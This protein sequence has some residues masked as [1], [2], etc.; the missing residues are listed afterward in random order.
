MRAIVFD[1][2]LRF[3]ANRPDPRPGDGECLIRI[4]QAG[5]CATDLHIIKGYMGFR[6]VPGHEF[7]GTVFNS[8]PAWQG[9]RVVAEINCV[10]R[11]CDMC[12][13]GLANHCRSRRVIGIADHDGAFADYVCVPERNLHEVP[14]G[15]S[16]EEAVF[17][18]PLAA[19]Y[20]VVTQCSIDPRMKVSV[21]GSGRLGLLVAQVLALTGCKLCVVGRNRA[22]LEFCEKKG[23]QAIHLDDLSAKQDQ[24][25]VVE[26]SGAPAGMDVALRLVRPRGTIV[27]K[28][29]YGDGDAKGPNLAAAVVNEVRIIGSRCGPFQEA[30]NALARGAIE[31]RTMISKAYPLDKGVEAFAA[32]G[33]PRNLKVMIRMDANRRESR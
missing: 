11:K 1:G 19:A 9:K 10:C 12:Q 30:I 26:C 29:T 27:L 28:S 18:E 17:I 6:G 23:I 14:A 25:I 13:T 2:Q 22:K 33:D 32:A 8:S 15:L 5:I 20:Q 7:V 24:E 4:H 31:V 21:V 16:D 3:D